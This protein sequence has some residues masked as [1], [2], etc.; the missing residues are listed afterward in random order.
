[1]V[2]KRKTTKKK[3]V[4][5]KIVYRTRKDKSP[6]SGINEAVRTGAGAVITFGVATAV[7]KALK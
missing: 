4:K 6:F 1:M 5:T 7:M 3:A 2:T